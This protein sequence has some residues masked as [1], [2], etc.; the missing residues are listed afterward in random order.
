MNQPHG[1]E[2]RPGNPERLTGRVAHGVT[3]LFGTSVLLQGLSLLTQLALG[4]WLSEDDFG[5]YAI[6]A[7]FT[8]L[9]QIFRDGGV[10][11]WLSRQSPGN[12]RI[13]MAPAFWLSLLAGTVVCLALCLVAPIA[14]WT[15]G[16]VDVR[17]LIL[18]IGLSTPL[19]S[20]PVVPTAG[21]QVEMKFR[22]LALSRALGVGIRY[23]LTIVFA[24]FGLGVYSLVLPLFLAGPMQALHSVRCLDARPDTWRVPLASVRNVLRG[25]AWALIG[26]LV[27]ALFR[28]IDYLVLG[29]FAPIGVLGVYYFAYQLSVQP[30]T[31]FAEN[32]RKVVIPSIAAA[33]GD[34]PRVWRAVRMASTLLGAVVGPII[35]WLVVACD[36]LEWILWRG[37]WETAVPAIRALTWSMPVQAFAQFSHMLAQSAGTYRLWSTTTAV[38]GVILGLV[39]ALAAALRGGDMATQ[40]AECVSL[41]IGITGIAE[42]IVIFQRLHLPAWDCVARFA[43]PYL[44]AVAVAA[45]VVVW[46]P[47]LGLPGWQRVV[48]TSALYLAGAGI[49]IAV[50]FWAQG[51]ELAQFLRSRKQSG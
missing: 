28:Q 26:A 13:Q 1:D 27:S 24:A 12:F 41:A 4:W 42:A 33:E 31:I 47:D 3:W 2:K 51:V 43:G 38:R 21:L 14:S 20:L 16:S 19:Q 29:L 25:S 46:K 6:A 9:L 8:T 49:G 34:P 37:R 40:V 35:L 44:T 45:V 48:V 11:L 17:G 22:E 32:L 39:T 5:V 30:G 23:G 36:D 50:F 10:Q 7:S 18:W 15:Y